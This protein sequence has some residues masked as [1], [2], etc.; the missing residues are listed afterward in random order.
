MADNRKQVC[1]APP[2]TDNRAY[3]VRAV[4]AMFH[5][6]ERIQQPNTPYCR[7]PQT[8]RKTSGLQHPYSYACLSPRKDAHDSRPPCLT[9]KP[10]YPLPDSRYT[11]SHRLGSIP[12]AALRVYPST[13]Q[14]ADST[15]CFPLSVRPIQA[16]CPYRRMLI[17]GE[18]GIAR[19]AHFALSVRIELK[20][21]IL[22]LII[23]GFCRKTPLLSQNPFTPI[24][25][26]LRKP[27]QTPVQPLSATRPCYFE[28]QA[29]IAFT[30][31]SQSA[32]LFRSICSPQVHSG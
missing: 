22:H 18:H 8:C 20:R 23:Y 17:G 16:D 12:H 27:M 24:G 26:G 32:I 15:R 19:K 11:C 30:V 31:R 10:S 6:R 5:Y 3:P 29:C 21:K 7:E 14:E 1:P 9:G 2:S 4:H 28:R 25:D 13:S